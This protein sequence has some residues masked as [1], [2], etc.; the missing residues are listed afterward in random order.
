MKILKQVQEENRKFIIMANNPTAKTYEEALEM[1]L[2][3]GC[4]ASVNGNDPQP[5][6][7]QGF[8]YDKQ[9]KVFG[10]TYAKDIE[11]T[12]NDSIFFFPNC[13]DLKIIGKPLT[14]DRV[15][16]AFKSMGLGYLNDSLFV[17]DN[18]IDS[19]YNDE[20]KIICDWDLTKETLEEQSE[21]T[22][23]KFNQLIN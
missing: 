18:N 8:D 1:E 4:I 11:S 12:C 3:V 20:K 9:E 5:I 13:S 15:L 23:R 21:E 7:A 17:I 14:L 6:V 16:I 22:Q 19:R 10:F 2:G